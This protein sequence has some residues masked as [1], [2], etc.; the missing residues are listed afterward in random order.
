LT[1]MKL[2]KKN[3]KYSEASVLCDLENCD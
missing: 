3:F 1:I 2:G